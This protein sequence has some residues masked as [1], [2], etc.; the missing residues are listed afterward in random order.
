MSLLSGVAVAGGRDGG[1]GR[2]TR[3]RGMLRRWRGEIVK[4]KKEGEEERGDRILVMEGWRGIGNGEERGDS[5][6]GKKER[7]GRE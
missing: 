6:L 5:K 1:E 7:K 4:E 3:L 2:K